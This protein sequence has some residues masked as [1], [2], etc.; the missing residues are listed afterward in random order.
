MDDYSNEKVLTAMTA[1]CAVRG[2][3]C[4]AKLSESERSRV[5]KPFRELE[6]ALQVVYVERLAIDFP[7][8]TQKV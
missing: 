5:W 1:L 8:D 6:R 4:N 3:L 7:T 2:E